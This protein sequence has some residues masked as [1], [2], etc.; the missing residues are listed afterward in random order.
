MK[1][2]IKIYND[3]IKATGIPRYSYVSEDVD[4]MMRGKRNREEIQRDWDKRNKK[5]KIKRILEK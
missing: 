1:D 2:I 4:R 3:M 5:Q